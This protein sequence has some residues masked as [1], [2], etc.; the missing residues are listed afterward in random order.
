MIIKSKK[1]GAGRKI[2]FF[3][4]LPRGFKDFTLLWTLLYPIVCLQIVKSLPEF[5]SMK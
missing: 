3:S 2:W 4:T 5:K 1:K